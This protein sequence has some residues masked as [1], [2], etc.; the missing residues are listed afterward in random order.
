V[1]LRFDESDYPFGFHCEKTSLDHQ[2]SQN[3][4]SVSYVKLIG[5]LEQTLLI[6]DLP[7]KTWNT[8]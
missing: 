3:L 2:V 8:D 6:K 1:F 7:K 4:P 5:T